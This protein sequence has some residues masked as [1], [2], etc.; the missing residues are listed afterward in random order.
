MDRIERTRVTV[1]S[2]EG[3]KARSR[4]EPRDGDAGRELAVPLTAFGGPGVRRLG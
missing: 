3:G 4:I 2:V 1:L